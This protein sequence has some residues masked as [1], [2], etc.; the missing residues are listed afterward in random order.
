[1]RDGNGVVFVS[2]RG[3][4]LPAGFLP[5]PHLGNVREDSLAAVYSDSPQLAELRNMNLLKGKCGDREFRWLCGGSPARA[6]GMTGD[7]MESDPS[8]T[9]EPRSGM[10]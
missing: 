1:M 6:Y 2:H 8:C 10:G 5:H 9:Y 7:A 3:D 4:V